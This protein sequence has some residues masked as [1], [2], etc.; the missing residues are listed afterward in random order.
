M[1]VA[2]RISDTAGLV[3]A[4]NLSGKPVVMEIVPQEIAAPAVSGAAAKVPQVYYLIPSACTVKI[5]D[6]A[7]L[8]MQ[9]RVPVYQLGKMA[10]MPVNTT[11]Q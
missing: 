3:P 9:T 1:Y 4:D 11:L 7:E 5:K 8:L 2:F 10:S 6:G